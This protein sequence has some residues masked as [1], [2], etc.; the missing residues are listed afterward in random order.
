M[1]R[2]L[3]IDMV[4]GWYHVTARGIERRAIFDDRR[5][6]E[7][8]W[9]LLQETVERFRIVIHAHV[10]LV[11]HYHLIVQTP[12]AN[13][14]R[15]IQWLNVS[16]AAWFN[17]RN[18]RVGPLFQGRFKS[19]PVQDSAWAYELSL[20]VHLNPVM[21]KAHGLDKAGKRIESLGFEQPDQ[22]M[23]TQRLSELRR[24]P[25][26]SYRA[27]AGYAKPPDWLRSGE[28]L[29]RA[30]R[31][32]DQRVSIY[33]EDVRQRLTK[34]VD[35][36][37][38]ERLT[39]GFALGTE[40]FREQVR[41]LAKGGREITQTRELRRRV[42]FTDLLAMVETL[43]GEKLEDLLHQRG[44]WARPILLWAARRYTGMTLREIGAAA[45]D[46]DYTAVAMTIKRFEQ[47]A[48]SNENLRRHMEQIKAQ[49]EM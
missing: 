46:A 29:R 40:A 34:G 10:E 47:K 25:W 38:R 22:A 18:N 43:R 23:V 11:N 39:D 5:D 32:I 49:C 21:R 6:H 28:I 35:P 3:R 4:D 37:I 2:P 20:Y 13:L 16:Y 12:D 42:A 24:Y 44:D 9:D 1:A 33:R 8:L 48:A 7:H 19:I 30:S 45:G 36:D 17:R 14:S 15:A 41:H 26:S 27:Y 31:R